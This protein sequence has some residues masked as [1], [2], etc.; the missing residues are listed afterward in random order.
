MDCKSLS[1]MDL[2]TDVSEEAQYLREVIA[3]L[4]ALNLD[5]QERLYA[6]MQ[7][8][9][10][11]LAALAL[12]SLAKTLKSSNDGLREANHS[13]SSLL[14][15]TENQSNEDPIDIVNNALLAIRK[16]LISNGIIRDI[17]RMIGSLVQAGM[18][19]MAP[20]A[21][22]EAAN[23]RPISPKRDPIPPHILIP[24]PTN[25]PHPQPDDLMRPTP[26][27]VAKSTRRVARVPGMP[28][29][30]SLPQVVVVT[31]DV[32]PSVEEEV[33]KKLVKPWKCPK[34]VPITPLHR[35][36][37]VTRPFS[38]EGRKKALSMHIEN[39]VLSHG[40]RQAESDVF[41][42]EVGLQ[43]FET[44]FPQNAGYKFGAVLH[45]SSPA[46]AESLLEPTRL[47][48]AE[49]KMDDN[50]HMR[51]RCDS[52]TIPRFWEPTPYKPVLPKPRKP[53]KVVPFSITER[54]KICYQSVEHSSHG[55]IQ[56]VKNVWW[57]PVTVQTVV[58][59]TPPT[60]TMRLD[61]ITRN[62]VSKDLRDFTSNEE[63]IAAAK[64][65]MGRL[66]PLF[67]RTGLTR[68]RERES[69]GKLHFT[70]YIT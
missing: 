16:E 10:E 29:P 68:R 18:P 36:P 8:A 64:D 60:R 24:L 42:N 4:E 57:E 22:A 47:R 54:E 30:L 38:F 56:A 45:S 52:V 3:T 28:T 7:N 66:D 40:K 2:P 62:I 1:T 44:P 55:K 12:N 21:K 59:Q 41:W 58:P 39:L 11:L 69:S 5:A 67:V 37:I 27:K 51:P 26:V 19:F 6:L 32:P 23:L 25:P 48:F 35:K 33:P 70:D 63:R 31:Q 20:S 53:I 14:N 9:K 13:S 50:G 43:R 61:Q 49:F 17:D 65:L 46:P 15:M 34:Y